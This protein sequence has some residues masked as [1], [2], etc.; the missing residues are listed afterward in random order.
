M[1]MGRMGR[2]SWGN[3]IVCY[4]G[5]KQCRADMKCHNVSPV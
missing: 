2:G 3:T 4:G 1:G 5:G